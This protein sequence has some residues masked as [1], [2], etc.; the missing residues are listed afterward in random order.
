MYQQ[1]VSADALE[2][3]RRA[4]ALAAKLN[5]HHWLARV[6]PKFFVVMTLAALG[7]LLRRQMNGQSLYIVALILLGTALVVAWAWMEARR[8]FCT[9]IQALVRLET[10]LGLHNRLSCAE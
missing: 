1:D 9:H 5:F 8:H 7:E 6:V 10:I 3:R 2:W 4:A